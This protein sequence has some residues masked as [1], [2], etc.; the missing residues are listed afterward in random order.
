M[1]GVRPEALR[2]AL[3]KV[4]VVLDADVKD[5]KV[6]TLS[7][8][9]LSG[10]GN[11]VLAGYDSKSNT[12]VLIADRIPKGW[13]R[14]VIMHELFHKRGG[15]FL[16]RREIQRL[17]DEFNSWGKEPKGSAER[18]IYDAAVP[19]ARAAVRSE[20]DAAKAKGKTLSAQQ[21]QT[22]YDEEILPYA[23]EEAVKLGLNVDPK[24]VLAKG[25]QGWLARFTKAV[26]DEVTRFLGHAPK[27]FNAVDL[28]TAAWGAA[29]LELTDKT[30]TDTLGRALTQLGESRAASAL[31]ARRTF[32]ETRA[33]QRRRLGQREYVPE[34]AT[35]KERN[36]RL[37]PS[38]VASA[39][40]P[41]MS[42][43]QSAE[44]IYKGPTIAKDLG[45][46]SPK[47]VNAR[48]RLQRIY[49]KGNER[50]EFTPDTA[51]DI[52]HLLDDMEEARMRPVAER[53]RGAD[54]LR[55]RLLRARRDG[56]LSPEQTNLALWLL[57][58]APQ[59]A[60]DL[61]ISI[62]QQPQNDQ[63]SAG[64]YNPA[65]RIATLFSDQANPNTG[66]HEILHHT[67]RMMPA[68]VRAGI[69]KAWWKALNDRINELRQLEDPTREQTNERIGLQ[70]LAQ[71][72]VAGNEKGLQ[73]F[74]QLLQAEAVPMSA[75][76]YYNPSEFWAVN[77]SDLI[78]NRAEAE[79]GG[80]IEQARQWLSELIE[81]AKGVF[82]L[83]D[84]APIIR[85]LN[86]VLEGDGSQ[87]AQSMLQVP[88][89][90][91]ANI[92]P[93]AQPLR[94]SP[95]DIAASIAG[96]FASP[97]QAAK[98]NAQAPAPGP[99]Q[100]SKSIYEIYSPKTA[101]PIKTRK[102]LGAFIQTKNQP[103]TE[104]A[105]QARDQFI[106]NWQD[107]QRPFYSWLRDNVLTLQPWQQ[108]K[109]IPGRLKALTDRFTRAIADPIAKDINAFAQKYKIDTSTASDVLGYWAMFRHV[110]E[111]NAALR[112]K[113]RA[114]LIAG[115]RG[116]AEALRAFDETQR[117][118]HPDEDDPKRARMAGGLT[119][120][121]AIAFRE[122]LERNYSVDDL[123]NTGDKIVAGFAT[124]KEEAIKSGQIS[125]EALKRFPKF[126]HY[127]ALTGLPWDD[128]ANDGFGTYVAPNLL[129]EREGRRDT[130]ADQSVKALMD[131]IGRVSAYTASVDF[132]KSLNDIYEQAGGKDNT[133]GLTRME[134]H[135]A[136]T[137]AHADII[138]QEKDGKRYIFRFDNEKIGE[139]L[140][141][142]NKEYADNAALRLMDR[143]TRVFSRA[144]TT[145]TA[146][147]GPVNTWRDVW[148]K[149]VLIRSRNVRDREG[150]LLSPND[151][152][153]RTFANA[154][155]MDTWRA[156]KQLA[157]DGKADE[158][159]LAGRLANEL[160]ERGGISTLAQKL[161]TGRED[162]AKEARKH[163]GLRKGTHQFV[164]FVEK[165]NTMMEVISTLSAHAAMRDLNVDPNEAAFQALDLMNFQNQGAKTRWLRAM[166][167]FFNPA[168]QSGYN[169]WRQLSTPRGQRDAMIGMALLSMLYMLSRATGDDDEELGN[170]MDYRGSYE[171]ERNITFK[172]G[173]T[174]YKIP[175]PFGLQQFLYSTIVNTARYA[176][177]RYNAQD[178]VAQQATSFIKTFSPVPPSEVEFTKQ[179][180]NFFFKSITPSVFKGAVDMVTDTNAWGQKLT[181][182]FPQQ[183]K[184]ESEQGR[185][186]TPKFY[187][188]AAKNIRELTGWDLYPEQWRALME[189]VAWGPAGYALKSIADSNAEAEGRK[190]DPLDQV[191]G[192][193]L[194]RL[195]GASRFVGGQSRYVES[196]YHDTF[197]KA[198]VDVKEMNAAKGAGKER[199]WR[200]DNPEKAQRADAL[201]K[202]RT[203]L[204][205]I[206]KDYNAVVKAMQT[207][208]I[209]VE[210]G[211]ERLGLIQDRREALMREF[212][213]SNRRQEA[214]Y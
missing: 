106:E 94:K 157:F 36:K 198:M 70:M 26:R 120:S 137:P 181:A 118:A 84:R 130:V 183:G 47:R 40:A 74:E 179:P 61:G 91:Q 192:S 174:I 171:A 55:E 205:A 194:I 111:A 207:E 199:E 116:A 54:Y 132:K 155:T 213:R 12:V 142:K 161:A 144:Y 152:F 167:A 18:T 163:A 145:W 92:V 30:R 68:P 44:E 124:M 114:R 76:Q 108:L 49:E 81:K 150:N 105:P 34:T 123:K 90:G 141:A 154:F 135:T 146:A 46:T 3:P 63:G 140:L 37:R 35:E 113:I 176:T 159:T 153:G 136:Q 164:D 139:A 80:W 107:Y 14:A 173:G 25:A 184:F 23:V 196:A 32:A 20:L 149:A 206:A 182:Y 187:K 169:L 88:E 7:G 110:P 10:I 212:L 27:S 122:E 24:Q 77:G 133:I 178:A 99:N 58:R 127:V 128:T 190:R 57:D 75:Y 189:G 185:T 197:G 148:E 56:T 60:N 87:L 208:Q 95:R 66:A 100:P 93:Q 15:Q 101:A 19:R 85:A 9:Q 67:E 170:E 201:A 158:S 131:R 177:G 17:R 96:I 210:T 59:V 29:Q 16:G 53:A 109:L 97:S 129:R 175:V 45:S 50:A 86:A 162:I 98:A 42:N 51:M 112:D 188:D 89:P 13:E 104:W 134:S 147:F 82:G 2:R 52:E 143:A 73:V 33:E 5:G 1:F 121:E 78:R 38:E 72:H 166:F 203:Q 4:E 69:R 168:V 65:A 193:S 79:E 214:D 31:R 6:T 39:T 62:R 204:M 22:I 202:Q 125:Q 48:R 119:D 115:E 21:M 117:G 71:A 28:M 186:N 211:R 165:Y 160:R 191:P 151:L 209:D 102:Q 156:A 180:V 83:S 200:T 41:T 11:T 138:Y 195:L 172:L 64:F 126:Q 8:S 43:Q 103:T